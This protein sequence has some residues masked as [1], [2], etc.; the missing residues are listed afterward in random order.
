MSSDF[1]LE[2]WWRCRPLG[3]K[4]FSC[5]V[6]KHVTEIDVV[7]YLPSLRVSL[8]TRC[9]KFRMQH[10]KQTGDVIST[11]IVY[12]LHRILSAE[13]LTP[14]KTKRGHQMRRAE[15]HSTQISYRCS[16]AMIRWECFRAVWL[17]NIAHSRDRICKWDKI[18]VMASKVPPVQTFSG[19]TTGRYVVYNSAEDGVERYEVSKVPQ[20]A[21]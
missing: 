12:A 10:G 17:G 9:E 8:L 1:Q 7:S 20:W 11:R 21:V 16:Q 18:S 2:V 4:L 14:Q 15:F 19:H 3:C 5:T 13:T 6:P